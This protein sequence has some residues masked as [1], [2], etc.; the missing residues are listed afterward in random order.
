MKF[1]AI[2][3]QN[4]HEHGCVRPFIAPLFKSTNA[5]MCSP[6]TGIANASPFFVNEQRTNSATRGTQNI[7]IDLPHG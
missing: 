3:Q 4:H 2:G 6:A 5:A 1:H 7:A